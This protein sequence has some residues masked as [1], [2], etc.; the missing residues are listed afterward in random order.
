V[1]T[2]APG[3]VY[4]IDFWATWCS[5]CSGTIA[6]LSLLQEKYRD[7]GLTVIGVSAKDNL[8]TEQSVGAFVKSHAAI[9]RYPT[10]WCAES[11]TRDAYLKASGQEG[12][13]CCFVIDRQGKIAYIGHP[14]QLEEV[15]PKVLAGTWRA[16][17]DAELLGRAFDKL[18]DAVQEARADPAKALKMFTE[19]EQSHPRMTAYVDDYKLLILMRNQRLEESE[20]LF[21]EIVAESQ[22]DQDAMKLVALCNYWIAAEINP[23]RHKLTLAVEAAEAAQ[24]IT[25]GQDMNVNATS[26]QV[27]AVAGDRAKAVRYAKKAMELAPEHFRD[28][29]WQMVGR[30]K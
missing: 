25:G 9:L 20:K 6:H 21:R 23:K 18:L 19:L 30:I 3:Q 5:A 8:N 15:V 13:P 17:T 16:G 11:A 28:Q 29:V 4:V 1:K 12:L 7:K 14:M 22:K 2:L 10:G 26:A 24:K 27:H